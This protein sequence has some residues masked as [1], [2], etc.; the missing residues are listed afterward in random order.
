MK[1]V[2][3][4]DRIFCLINLVFFLFGLCIYADIYTI[5]YS[6]QHTRLTIN[7]TSPDI[8]DFHY[9]GDLSEETAL[10]NRIKHDLNMDIVP[11]KMD[12]SRRYRQGQIVQDINGVGYVI[13]INSDFYQQLSPKKKLALIGHEMGHLA[14]NWDRGVEGQIGADLIAAKYVGTNIMLSFLDEDIYNDWLKTQPIYRED[15]EARHNALL[16]KLR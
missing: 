9:N 13:G 16:S 5:V 8:P 4:I 2:G 6:Y 3:I 11:I 14:G 1:N 10:I 7:I 15:W 12:F